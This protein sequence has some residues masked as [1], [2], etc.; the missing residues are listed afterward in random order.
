MPLNKVYDYIIAGGGCAGLSLV[1][2]MLKEPQLSTKKIL[3][4]DKD[5]KQLNDPPGVTG[6]REK[7]FLMKLFTG[8]GKKPGFMEKD[9]HP[10]KGLILTPTR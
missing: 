1:M 3:I 5:S 7:A 4:I 10:S 8:N 2:R 6:K 9:I